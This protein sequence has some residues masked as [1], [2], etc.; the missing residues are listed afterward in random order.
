MGKPRGRAGSPTEE[1]GRYR[2]SSMWEMISSTVQGPEYTLQ[3][4]TTLPVT[5][6]ERCP[7]VV[8]LCRVSR[9]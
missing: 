8:L 3:I 5:F 1:K 4:R 7:A 9:T 2:L 6:A